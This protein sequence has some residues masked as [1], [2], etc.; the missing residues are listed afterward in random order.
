MTP[1]PAA[2]AL[3]GEPARLG[4]RFR[5]LPPGGLGS[6]RARQLVYR[7][8]YIQREH[9]WVWISGLFEPL[10]YLLSIGV[11][12]GHL[13]GT[14][15]FDGRQ[16]RYAVF[17]APGLLATS[18]MNG[19]IYECTINIFAK[20]H[21]LKLYD[22]ITA[23]PLTPEDIA[24]GEIVSAVIRAA[25]YGAAFL[26]TMAILGD[27]GSWWSLLCLPV[28]VLIGT[29]FAASG[30]A[31]TSYMHSWTDFDKINVAT[32]PMFLFSATFY[33]LSTFPGWL[34][35]LVQCTP[36]YHGINLCRSLCAGSLSWAMLGDLAY[37]LAMIVAAVAV[38]GRRMRSLLTP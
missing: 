25:I 27:V 1:E 31:A 14:I 28:V 11:G 3:G 13:I 32:V 10:L 34:Q 23:T 38:G 6:T 26:L 2:A 5:I 8:L 15:G 35:V 24:V 37:L 30:L 19:A 22:A 29:A 33:P 36:L 21:W 20:L 12:I 9:P 16:V 7:N 18:A 4:L 17:V